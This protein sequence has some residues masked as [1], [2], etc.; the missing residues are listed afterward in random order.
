MWVALRLSAC[1]AGAWLLVPSV[2]LTYNLSPVFILYGTVSC[3]C[4]HTLTKNSTVRLDWQVSQ[5]LTLFSLP[6]KCWDD[7]NASMCLAF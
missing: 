6:P 1:T 4:V 2:Q 3:V 7:K 5:L